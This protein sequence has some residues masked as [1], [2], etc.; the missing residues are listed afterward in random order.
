LGGFSR[1][2]RGSGVVTSVLALWISY[3]AV[4][5]AAASVRLAATTSGSDTDT[6]ATMAGALVGAF[7]EEDP[8]GPVQDAHLQA[9]EAIRLS[10]LAAGDPVDSFP[11][12]DSL[13]WHPPRSMSDAVGMVGERT[14]V[15]GLGFAEPFSEVFSGQGREQV[16][17]Q[18][19][20]LDFG[21]TV[22][23][24]RR[25]DLRP[26]DP[27]ALPRK[28]P[29]PPA[30]ESKTINEQLKPPSSTSGSDAKATIERALLAAVESNFEA[31]V[32]GQWI[33]VL[34]L[35]ADGLSLASAFAGLVA[36]A[37]RTA[38]T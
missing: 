7:V 27:V 37:L 9:D 16:G 30:T 5:D 32:V 38:D 11:H 36:S 3:F 14:A 26:L 25:L 17:W 19:M 12:P 33:R 6:V 10:R 34:A 20:R 31:A 21:Q 15:A 18:W 13:G 1:A 8:P 24:K 29:A 35:E 23:I 22:L 2:T 28:R 4:N